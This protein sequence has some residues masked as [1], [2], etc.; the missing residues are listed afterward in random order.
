L[1]RHRTS[2]L[3]T[4]TV[5]L[6]GAVDADDVVQ[7]ASERAWRAIGDVD[8]AR[9]FRSWYLRVVANTA[10]NQRRGRWRRRRAELRVAARSSSGPADPVDD[11]VTA[12]ERD[13]VVAALNRLDAAERLVIALRH[14]EQLSEREMADV[15]DCPAGTVKS[16]LARA[17]ARLRAEL[18]ME[19]FDGD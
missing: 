19:A 15:L 2:A 4:A 12:A 7:T 5:V 16:R 13:V 10:R 3:R 6:G 18:S 11:T 17:M 14:F 1:S 8:A 9:G